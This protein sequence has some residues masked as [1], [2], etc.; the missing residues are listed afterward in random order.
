MQNIL[1]IDPI[2]TVKRMSSFSPLLTSIH[3]VAHPHPHHHCSVLTYPVRLRL[4]PN[5]FSLKAI[6]NCPQNTKID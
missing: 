6:H 5:V 3:P 1:E 2:P 4:C